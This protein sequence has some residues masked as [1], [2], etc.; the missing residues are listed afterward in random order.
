MKN[1][2]YVHLPAYREPE[3]IPT[4]KDCIAKAKNPKRLV[5]GICRQFHPD[6][7]FDN[8]DEYRNDKRFKIIDIPH[9]QAKG[10]PY[11]RYRINELI[12]NETYILQLDSHHRFTDNWDE[13]LIDMHSN[14]EKKGFKPILTGYLPYYSPFN[15]PAGRCQEPWQ[16][17]F[18]SFYPHGTIFIRPGLLEGWQTRTEPIRS[19]FLSGHFCFA[20]AE[21]GKEIKHDPLIYFSGE[22]LN[23]TVRSFTHG[24]DFFHPHKIVIWHATMREERAGKLVWDDQ[25]KR[26]EN[27]FQHQQIAWKRIRTLLRTENNPDVDLTGYDLGKVRTLRDFEKYAGFHFK[28][29]GVQ[30]Y[31]YENKLPPNPPSAN[32]EEWEKS[33]MTSFYHLI[34]FDKS[35]FKLDDY[36]YFVVAFDDENGQPIHREDLNE[37]QVKEL[38]ARP[39]QWVSLERFFLTEKKPHRWVIWGYSKSKGWDERIEHVI[40]QKK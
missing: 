38:L 1:T 22:E 40:E 31:T 37:A 26:G 23:L 12:T 36:A 34:H 8:L 28:K 15:D 19:R 13:T 2:I 11:A 5:F 24:Y 7:K 30:R 29:K 32:D 17:Q 27:W 6:D 33:F 18:A 21:W 14:L 25:H 16:Q 3:L 4:I 39:D 20:R 9:E 35:R 10:L